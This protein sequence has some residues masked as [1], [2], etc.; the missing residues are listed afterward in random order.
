[1]SASGPLDEAK[2]SSMDL[3]KFMKCSEECE[4]SN[5]LN[6]PRTEGMPVNME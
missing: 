3:V 4:C 5:C 1:M 6:M 2:V